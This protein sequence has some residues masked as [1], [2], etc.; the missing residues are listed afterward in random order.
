ARQGDDR[1]IDLNAIDGNRSVNG[2]EL[3]WNGSGTQSNNTNPAHLLWR[4][5]RVI[6]IG[7]DQKIIPGALCQ[8]LMRIIDRVNAQALVKHQLHFI[9]YAYYLNIVIW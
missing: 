2:T 9:A 8:Y 5:G 6:E 7:S 4:I 1:A 3:T